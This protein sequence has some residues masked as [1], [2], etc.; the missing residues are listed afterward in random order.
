MKTP[1]AAVL[2]TILTLASV[3]QIILAIF[4]CNKDG[5]AAAVNL[6]WLILWLS[7]IFGWLPIY[8]LKKWG[9]V[10]KDLSYI[11]TTVLVDW[12]IYAIVPHPQ[13]L[14]GMLI[15]LAL[16]LIS[17]HWAVALLGVVVVIMIY[18]SSTS[19]KNRQPSINLGRHTKRICSA[20]RGLI[21]CWACFYIY[22]NLGKPAEQWRGLK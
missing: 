12:G 11:H 21:S 19:M 8:T 9:G 5:T 16:P 15:G 17:Q 20:C 13:Y 14:A 22:P 1:R 18:I 6:G 2:A 3:G 7:A 10:P 4:L